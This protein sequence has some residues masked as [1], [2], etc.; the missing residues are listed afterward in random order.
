[1]SDNKLTKE[2]FAPIRERENGDK[3]IDCSTEDS[4]LE[5]AKELTRIENGKHEI[6]AKYNPVV[7]YARCKVSVVEYVEED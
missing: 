5:M 2:I 1:M 6:W 7:G 4:G 3:W